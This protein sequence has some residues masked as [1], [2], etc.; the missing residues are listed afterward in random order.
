[1]P[2]AGGQ[3]NPANVLSP[4]DT[5]ERVRRAGAAKGKPRRSRVSAAGETR[6][7]RDPRPSEL[8]RRAERQRAKPHEEVGP[9]LVLNLRLGSDW[10]NSTILTDVVDTM[11][12]FGVVEL[13]EI[14]EL[15]EKV[16]VSDLP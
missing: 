5:S 6:V 9:L 13:A 11:K 16:D 4:R 14:R 12:T 1:M 3:R 10:L 15:P 8:R 7:P 2:V